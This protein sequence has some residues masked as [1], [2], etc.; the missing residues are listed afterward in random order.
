[1]DENI[2]NLVIPDNPD[3]I[4]EDYRKHFKIAILTNYQNYF[5]FF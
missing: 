2:E 1:M 4:C 3:N 5:F